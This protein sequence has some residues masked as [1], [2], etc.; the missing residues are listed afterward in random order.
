MTQKGMPA[1]KAPKDDRSALFTHGILA[2]PK[3]LHPVLKRFILVAR[4]L[5]LF[6]FHLTTAWQWGATGGR[7]VAIFRWHYICR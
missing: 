1:S 3:R 6:G 2:D 4:A 5:T 7:H